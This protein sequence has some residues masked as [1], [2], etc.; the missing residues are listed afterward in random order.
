M[1]LDGTPLPILKLNGTEP[2]RSLDLSRHKIGAAS[3]VVI[4]L[5]VGDNVELTEVC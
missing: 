4:G 2:V 3:A 1:N 5:L